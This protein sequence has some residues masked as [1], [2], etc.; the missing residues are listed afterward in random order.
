MTTQEAVAQTGYI[1]RPRYTRVECDWDG[2][3][4]E[5]GAEPLWIEVKESNTWDEVD[6]MA[7]TPEQTYAER[8]AVIAPY[9]RSWNAMGLDAESGEMAPL[10]P[11]AEAGPSIFSALDRMVFIWIDMQVR[12]AHLGGLR[13]PK[14]TSVSEPTPEPSNAVSES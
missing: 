3:K 9:I 13:R 14:A 2:L 7:M 5:D 1:R 4:P 8:W 6:D 10:P 11:P 12:T